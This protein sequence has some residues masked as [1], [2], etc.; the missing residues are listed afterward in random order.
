MLDYVDK[1][2]LPDDDTATERAMSQAYREYY[3]NDGIL[4]HEDAMMPKRLVAV[5]RT[6]TIREP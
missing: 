3:V 4:Y 2:I 6:G 1:K 5:K